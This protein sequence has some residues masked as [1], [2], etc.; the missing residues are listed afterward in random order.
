MLDCY[1]IS[2]TDSVFTNTMGTQV[3][4]LVTCSEILFDQILV[5]DTNNIGI[6]VTTSDNVTISNSDFTNIPGECIWFTT[7]PDS[8]I[9]SNYF[10]NIGDTTIGL[11]TSSHRANISHNTVTD[12]TGDG[13]Y[14]SNSDNGT[15]S[16]NSISGDA[17]YGI[18]HHFSYNWR[19]HDNTIDSVYYGIEMY[20]DSHTDVWNN[21]ISM[22]AVGFY[23][24]DHGMLELCENTITQ[25]DTGIQTISCVEPYIRGNVITD[26]GDGMY[27]ECTN[28]DFS[29]NIISNCD[30]A[31][32]ILGGVTNTTFNGNN[33]S[34]CGY[35]GIDMWSVDYNYFVDNNLIECGFFLLI[36]PPTGHQPY[37]HSFSGNTVNGKPLFYANN[38][39]G[40]AVNGSIYGQKI[41]TNSTDITVTEG[42]FVKAACG[43]QIM[44]SNEISITDVSFADLIITAFVLVSKN[45]TF[46]DCNVTGTN[47]D[48]GI[49]IWETTRPEID[50]CKFEGLGGGL[51]GPSALSIAG[52]YNTSITDSWFID[53]DSVGVHFWQSMSFTNVYGFVTDCTFLN[54]SVGFSAADTTYLEVENNSFMWG[55]FALSTDSGSDF[56]VVQWNEI[57]YFDTGISRLFSDNWFLAN[58]TIRWN[59]VGVEIYGSV[60]T[61]T[62]DNIIALNIESN[63]VDGS[64]NFWDDGVDTGNYWDDYSG[65]GV[66][67]IDGAGGAQDRYPMQYIVT[68]PIM[69]TA[70]D[71]SY[72]EG[73]EG[74]EIFWLPFDNFLRDWTVTI[75]GEPWAS[76]AWN[77]ENITVNIDGLAYGTHT[78]FI[79]VWD[80]DNNYV[81]DTVIVTVYDDTPPEISGLPDHVLYIDADLTIDWEVSDLNPTDYNVTVDGV[82]FDTGTWSSGI[83]S[84]DFTGITTGHHNLTVIIY[85][86]DGN[87]ASD[88]VVVL[89]IEDDEDPTVDHPDDVV[90]IEGTTGNVVVWTPEDDHP[91]SYSV[92]FNGTVVDTGDWSG[93]RISVNVDGNAVGSNEVSITVYD[94]SGNSATDM[95]NVTVI[96]LI[97][98]PPVP[99]IDWTVLIIGAVVGGV[100][101]VVAIIYYLRKKKS[102]EY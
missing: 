14:V 27:L 29:S 51:M 81:N 97:Q 32:I 85:D 4:Y 65:S 78:V 17:E 89:V 38:L 48:G 64:A 63:G 45:V 60:G 41:I 33:I 61:T 72:P 12:I 74:N 8:S 99:M 44:Y 62:A 77:F 54:V 66:Y 83:L 22:C 20:Y 92:S 40:L 36:G 3:L 46:A 95:V 31:G 13:F 15:M 84:V 71:I 58:N 52:C 96:P 2:I 24:V 42:E 101:V 53:L 19:I 68:E 67:D 23:A 82:E 100:I 18:Y 16:Y 75:D 80:V 34:Y 39:T 10:E 26:S 35:A 28:G 37:N 91:D 55:D 11:T 88:L 93:S 90:Y 47:E 57:Q 59:T 49:F 86:V 7:T 102:G 69:N 21:Y 73:S 30:G 87:M 76:D 70:A 1:N 94:A 56:W 43:V 98:E 50:N 25:C 9:L 5:N 6:Q 79:T